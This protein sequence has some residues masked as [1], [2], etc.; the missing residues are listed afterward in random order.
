MQTKRVKIEKKC[1]FDL[2]GFLF[3]EFKNEKGIQLE[4]DVTRDINSYF[5]QFLNKQ[6][7]GFLR[8]TCKT[9]REKGVME[10]E[11]WGK[12]KGTLCDYAATHGFLFLMQWAHK[13]GY[14]WN[15]NTCTVA[16]LGGHLN[17]LQWLRKQDPPCPWNGRTCSRAAENGHLKVLKWLRK[18]YPPC[19]WNE[20]T[21][22]QAAENGHL[23]VLKW[24]RKQVP[25]CPWNEW[26]CE[27]AAENGHLNVLRYAIENKC[28]GYGAY[29]MPELRYIQYI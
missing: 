14:H 22:E 20:W 18:Q 21:C 27:Q 7:K 16:A 17:V 11:K 26:T 8:K 15:D 12:D 28:P 5:M 10:T 2:L 9:L 1:V 23:K 13:N 24:L 25:P 3:K 4:N 19:P 6:D 29:K